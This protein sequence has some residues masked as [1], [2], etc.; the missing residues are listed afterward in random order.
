MRQRL[1]P[2]QGR[3]RREDG[4]QGDKRIDPRLLAEEQGAIGH[5]K[6]SGGEQSGTMV[7][8]VSRKK[9][10]PVYRQDSEYRRW[11]PEI[12]RVVAG[13]VQNKPGDDVMEWRVNIVLGAGDRSD[14]AYAVRSSPGR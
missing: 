5:R 2:M 6:G 9:I 8:G 7:I 3:V 1:R 11:K 4:Q 12:K 13:V 10:D 14:Q